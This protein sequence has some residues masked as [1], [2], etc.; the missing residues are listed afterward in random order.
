MTFINLCYYPLVLLGHILQWIKILYDC[1][2]SAAKKC[3]SCCRTNS[4]ELDAEEPSRPLTTLD[5]DRKR[6]TQTECMPMLTDGF[7]PG[8]YFETTCESE[9]NS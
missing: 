8:P 1:V 9:L 5:V 7:E 2:K 3:C 4:L 6:A